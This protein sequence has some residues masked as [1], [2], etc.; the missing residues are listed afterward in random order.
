MERRGSE[1]EVNEKKGTMV[2]LAS[3]LWWSGVPL[4]P[5]TQ[6]P[7]TGR[8]QWRNSATSWVLQLL[9]A[10]SLLWIFLPFQQ[11]RGIILSV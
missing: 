2:G 5:A 11:L 8:S 7:H 6:E 10:F 4:W 3:S 9:V 1:K